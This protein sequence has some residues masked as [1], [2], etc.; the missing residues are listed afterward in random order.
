MSTILTNLKTNTMSVQ[1][2]ILW[3]KNHVV[4]EYNQT[5]LL[6]INS[7]NGRPKSSSSWM[8]HHIMLYPSGTGFAE[9]YPG[10]WISRSILSGLLAYR[11]YLILV[12]GITLSP[13]YTKFMSWNIYT[14]KVRNK[15]ITSKPTGSMTNN[16]KFH[17][18]TCL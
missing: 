12:A 15:A 16:M 10:R 6:E 17:I 18:Q 14:R 5:V 11:I 4:L 3:K 2:N 9:N 7:F 1:W 13:K 8:L